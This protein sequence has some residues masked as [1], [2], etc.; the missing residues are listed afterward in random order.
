MERIKIMG[1][2]YTISAFM[3]CTIAASR[4]IG[5][6]VAPTITVSRFVCV[7][8]AVWLTVRAFQTIGSLYR[9]ASFHG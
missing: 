1:C 2:S 3:D 4:G 8:R 6:S 7:F 9:A 5:K